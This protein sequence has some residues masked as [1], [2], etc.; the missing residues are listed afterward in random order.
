MKFKLSKAIKIDNKSIT[1]INV[2]FE[3]LTTVDYEQ[4]EREFKLTNQRL[5]TG[6]VESE[7]TFIKSVLVKAIDLPISAIDQLSINDFACLKVR[8][9]NFLLDGIRASLEGLEKPV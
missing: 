5:S 4:A 8:A 2:N 7:T 6:M 9:Q 3:N 1:E